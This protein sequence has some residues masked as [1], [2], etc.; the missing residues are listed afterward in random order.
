MAGSSSIANTGSR[1]FCIEINNQDKINPINRI[2]ESLYTMYMSNCIMA[3]NLELQWYL[4][5]KNPPSAGLRGF[6][7]GSQSH[8]KVQFVLKILLGAEGGWSHTVH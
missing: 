2:M 4:N 3:S 1:L 5:C 6:L 8:I 7:V